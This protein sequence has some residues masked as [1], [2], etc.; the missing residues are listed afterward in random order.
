MTLRYPAE[1]SR[2]RIWWQALAVYRGRMEH[3][4]QDDEKLDE[5]V[6]DMQSDDR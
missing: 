2:C 1:T 6:E 3:D 5:A 4:R